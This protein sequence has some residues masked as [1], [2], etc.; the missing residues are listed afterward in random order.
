[1]QSNDSTRP[2][3]PRLPKECIDMILDHFSFIRDSR[4]IIRSST[5][6]P[7]LTVNKDFFYTCIERFYRDPFQTIDDCGD[8][9]ERLKRFVNLLARISPCSDDPLVDNLRAA[10]S[11]ERTG[12]AAADTKFASPPFVDYLS[13]IQTMRWQP[14]LC[15][16]IG[17]ADWVDS[18]IR[19]KSTRVL[20]GWETLV[21]T[22]TKHG[23]YLPALRC[24]SISYMYLSRYVAC[25]KQMENIEMVEVVLEDLPDPE[26]A[27]RAVVPIYIQ[28]AIL[29]T[30]GLLARR[31]SQER[32]GSPSW[33]HG[34]DNGKELAQQQLHHHH[35]HWK[36]NPLQ[37]RFACE[38]KRHPRW[39]DDFG[40]QLRELYQCFP[41]LSFPTFAHNDH[42][43]DWRR[44]RTMPDTFDLLAVTAIHDFV[45]GVLKSDGVELFPPE[46]KGTLL[47]RCRSLKTFNVALHRDDPHD[48]HMFR[49]AVQEKREATS[50]KEQAVDRRDPTAHDAPLVPLEHLGLA[51][52]SHPMQ[53]VSTKVLSDATYAF[54][55]TLQSI[56]IHHSQVSLYLD[57]A[58]YFHDLPE[59]RRIELSNMG[60]I[61]CSGNA[62]TGC[63]KLELL[64][65]SDSHDDDTF[66]PFPVWD[67]PKLASLRA[68]GSVAFRFNQTSFKSIAAGLERLSLRSECES[69][70]STVRDTFTWEPSHWS[71]LPKL[72]ELELDGVIV[73]GFQWSWLIDICPRIERVTLVSWAF[74][75]FHS[76][77]PYPYLEEECLG[78]LALPS[79][80]SSSLSA[81]SV[82][83]LLSLSYLRIQGW[84]FAE[85]F[86]LDDLPMMAP[87]LRVIDA[88]HSQNL[89][90]ERVAGLA[91]KLRQLDKM[92][93]HEPFNQE[94][95][96]YGAKST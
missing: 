22:A 94:A 59:L 10:H 32:D 87:N 15:E 25:V 67:V 18:T 69:L 79:S 80:S 47:A 12:D 71:L 61:E 39:L 83:P 53:A 41:K 14:T 84:R 31:S 45:R 7:L 44:L 93:Y 92:I 13:Y 50:N 77:D 28:K 34:E 20:V 76:D 21:R 96:I 36:K 56:F 26:D 33:H 88:R 57:L 16:A 63:P 46:G 82:P 43:L 19:N 29:L 9:E 91:T 52:I 85:R 95:A 42:S 68:S 78:T 1:M 35:Q 40:P 5:L 60:K 66:H 49:W 90:P 62:F 58:L 70:D 17:R 30:K 48:I 8:V 2:F 74:Y 3:A 11:F 6:Y 27:R 54:S 24:I 37:V 73:K 38:G 4:R 51:V 23:S 81:S 72:R 55:A 75:N 64:H 65:L 89:V 86:F